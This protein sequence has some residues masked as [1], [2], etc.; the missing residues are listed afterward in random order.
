VTAEPDLRIE[1]PIHHAQVDLRVDPGF[2]GRL[3]FALPTSPNTWTSDDHGRDT[4]WLGPDQWLIVWARS[5]AGSPTA[6]GILD[7]IDTALDGAHH[8]AVEVTANRA[9]FAVGGPGRWEFLSHGCALDL[10]P[11]WWRDGMCAQ[12]L[13]ARVPVLLQERT[14]STRI[15]VR[16]SCV[17]YLR[18][19]FVERMSIISAAEWST[20]GGPREN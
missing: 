17:D 7:E 12:S 15:F 8:S 4:L 13:L 16:P 19:W 3:G 1:S 20:R 9:A 18:E 2:A 11:R 10:H 6:A 14:E 5:D